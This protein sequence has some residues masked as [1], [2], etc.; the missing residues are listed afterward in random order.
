MALLGV[1]IVLMSPHWHRRQHRLAG[2]AHRYVQALRVLS[3]SYLLLFVYAFSG[4]YSMGIMSRQHRTQATLFILLLLATSL[5]S[6]RRGG[7]TP[8]TVGSQLLLLHLP[9][10]IDESRPPQVAASPIAP[11]RSPLVPHE[12][13]PAS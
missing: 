2:A 4:M 13:R 8:K 6:K 5:V 7:R 3:I 9:P 12:P 10:E 11:T 1:A